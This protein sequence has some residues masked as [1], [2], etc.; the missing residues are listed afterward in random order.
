MLFP[1][2]T[3]IFHG[4]PL[5]V[6]AMHRVYIHVGLP[7]TGTSYL[8]ATLWASKDRLSQSGVLIPG[9]RARF[10]RY[11][12][13]DLLGRRLRG[14]AQPEV[15]GSWQALLSSVRSWQG[16]QVVLSEELLVHASRGVA[17][18]LVRDFRPA[19][20][21]VVVTVRDLGRVLGSM[22]QQDLA[23]ARTWTWP[24]FLAAVHDCEQGPATAGVAFWLRYDLRGVL[25]AWASVVPEERIHVVVVP[26]AGSAPTVLLERFA[27]AADL[28]LQALAPPDVKVNTAVGRV[29]AE[30]LRRLNTSLGRR[31]N[32]RQYRHIIN[33]LKPVLRSKA[34][35][36]S[37]RLPESE[38]RWVAEASSQLVEFLKSSSYDVVGDLDELLIDVDSNLGS[39]PESVTGEELAD[40]A[41]AALT[42]IAEHHANYWWKKRRRRRTSEADASARLSSAGR[43]IAF[44]AKIRAL[45]AADSHWF[46]ARAARL[47][48]QGRSR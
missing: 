34:S 17:R 22:W 40:A 19:E 32:E 2:R 36:G 20:V 7:K 44:A 37:I 33:L 47:Y 27:E 28:D 1:R 45:E 11:A 43:A 13:W 9:D 25:A 48:L 29:E 6:V 3:D 5:R 35:G 23:K 16:E 10:Q 18:R 42:A 46:L 38:R 31:L 15:P 30:L 14:V 24:E 12:V 39:D 21:H 41:M 4:I 26:G 8:Q